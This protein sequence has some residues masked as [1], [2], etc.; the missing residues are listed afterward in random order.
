MVDLIMNYVA[1]AG[2]TELDNLYTGTL[3]KMKII[4][5][6]Y[7]DGVA[8]KTDALKYLEYEK[9][10]QRKEKPKYSCFMRVVQVT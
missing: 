7:I 3:R 6:V 8:K 10:S 2:I 4:E 5:A 1:F 9:D